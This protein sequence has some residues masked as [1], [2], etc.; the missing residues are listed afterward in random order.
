MAGGPHHLRALCFARQE[1]T[2]EFTPQVGMLADVWVIL[3]YTSCRT[4][5]MMSSLAERL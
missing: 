3:E 5:E 4:V 2:E 1:G